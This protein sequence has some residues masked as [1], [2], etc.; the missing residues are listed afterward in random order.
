MAAALL[1]GALCLPASAP[2]QVRTAN[3]SN[4]QRD[5]RGANT[6]PVLD[7]LN[8]RYDAAA[9][10]LTIYLTFFEPI[11][12]TSALSGWEAAVYLADN[13]GT[14]QSPQCVPLLSRHN[15][16]ITFPLAD[17]QVPAEVLQ[18][19]TAGYRLKWSVSPDRRSVMLRSVDPRLANLRLVCA[20]A[21]LNGPGDEFSFIGASLFS[22]FR[23]L[24][25]NLATTARWHLGYEVT[26][27]NNRLGAA[28][29]DPPLGDFPR[30]RRTGRRSVQCSGRSRLRD[31]GGRPTVSVRGRMVVSYTRDLRTRWRRDMRATVAWRRCPAAVDA[32]R[33]G[34]RCS[35]TRRWRRG[36]LARRFRSVGAARAGPA[37]HEGRALSEA[38]RR[39]L[40]RLTPSG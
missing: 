15:F 18:Y 14:D 27:L 38:L 32:D 37:G 21:D 2:A 19:G 35:I 5:E 8:V 28:R 20:N 13:V 24:D 12:E 1:L 39:T 30:C 29:R 11:A 3:G 17:E 26:Q 31:V 36:S 4:A 16:L 40:S 10:D 25:G 33:A 22:G 6:Q 7:A 9:G 23:A 34:R